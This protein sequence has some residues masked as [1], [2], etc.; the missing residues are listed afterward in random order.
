[1]P[2][3]SIICH[4]TDMDVVVYMLTF[5]CHSD[6]E[7]VSSCWCR[8]YHTLDSVQFCFL[9]SGQFSLYHCVIAAVSLLLQQKHLYHSNH[10]RSLSE[11]I[12]LHW[13]TVQLFAVLQ[14]DQIHSLE[15]LGT[16]FLIFSCSQLCG[17]H[18]L[19]NPQ[20]Y[21]TMFAVGFCQWKH[22]NVSQ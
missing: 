12:A 21:K 22:W 7:E 19:L 6:F 10:L 9:Y 13:S 5:P 8:L 4:K 18:L 16:A 2:Y 20:P 14:M 3:W 15:L 11:M 17:H 1:M